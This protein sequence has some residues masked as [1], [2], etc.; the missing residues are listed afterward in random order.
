[1]LWQHLVFSFLIPKKHW[2]L[3]ST[4]EWLKTKW[5]LICC[6]APTRQGYWTVV[7]TRDRTLEVSIIFLYSKNRK[8]VIPLNTL[9]FENRPIFLT[10]NW[11]LLQNTEQAVLAVI[12]NGK[13]S[14]SSDTD[15]SSTLFS[16][17]KVHL[18]KVSRINLSLLH[19]WSPNAVLSGLSNKLNVF[20]ILI[21]PI[22]LFFPLKAA[23]SVSTSCNQVFP[24]YL[25]FSPLLVHVL[26]LFLFV[27]F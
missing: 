24:L 17:A 5:D 1:M 11:V 25:D 8:L 22:P 12:H 21:S 16:R 26:F 15:V 27:C 14:I 4:Q 18:W 6:S 10:H 2:F 3:Y 19:L 23:T 13:R 9:N 7:S 20:C